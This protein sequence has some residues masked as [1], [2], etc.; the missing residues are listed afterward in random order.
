MTSKFLA[1]NSTIQDSP[2][3]TTTSWTITPRFTPAIAIR[4]MR[5]P[6][7][8]LVPTI[9]ATFGPGVAIRIAVA[10]TKTR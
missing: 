8:R 5:A 4:P 2:A 3:A 10:A 9:S 1:N 7:V 6:Y